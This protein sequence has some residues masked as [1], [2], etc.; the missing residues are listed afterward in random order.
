VIT[1]KA[2]EA[3]KI[4]EVQPWG[5]VRCEGR[6]TCEHERGRQLKWEMASW[7]TAVLCEWWR[8]VGPPVSPCRGR[9]QT[10]VRCGR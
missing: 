10:S 5:T 2:V 3:V 4:L 6:G 1:V 8:L 9:Y 7:L